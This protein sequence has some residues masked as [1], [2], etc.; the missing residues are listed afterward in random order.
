MQDGLSDETDA[1]AG[2]NPGSQVKKSCLRLLDLS[3]N[4]IDD[5]GVAGIPHQ[6]CV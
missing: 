2:S 4:K 1:A 3:K 6:R 5:H